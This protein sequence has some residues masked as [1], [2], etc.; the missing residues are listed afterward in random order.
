[1][2]AHVLIPASMTLKSRLRAKVCRQDAGDSM[3][4]QARRLLTVGAGAVAATFLLAS[5]PAQAADQTG[6]AAFVKAN[7]LAAMIQAPHGPSRLRPSAPA[8]GQRYRD[9]DVGREIM[10]DGYDWISGDGCI[11]TAYD[12]YYDPSHGSDANDGVTRSTPKAT[13]AATLALAKSLYPAGGFRIGV[14]CGVISREQLVTDTS[15]SPLTSAVRVGAFT[16]PN[17]P[18]AAQPLIDG[19]TPIVAA[20]W[21]AASGGGYQA[22]VTFSQ[23]VTS[24]ADGS[25]PNVY[26]NGRNLVQ[27]TSLANCQAT[28]GTYWYS[29]YVGSMTAATTVTLTINDFDSSNPATNGKLYEAAVNFSGIYTYAPG[30]LITNINSRRTRGYPGSMACYGRGTTWFNCTI[31]DGNKHAGFLPA[32]GKADSCRF[33]NGYNG[34]YPAVN[35]VGGGQPNHLVF[36]DSGANLPANTVTNCTFTGNSAITPDANVASP[37]ISG[38]ISHTANGTDLFGGYT[39]TGCTFRNLGAASDCALSPV[40]N[41]NGNLYIDCTVNDDGGGAGNVVTMNWSNNQHVIVNLGTGPN[42]IP[43]LAAGSTLNLSNC[44]ISS[45]TYEPNVNSFQANVTL[46]LSGLTVLVGNT[47]S[48]YPHG[49]LNCTNA[50]IKLNLTNSVLQMTYAYDSFLSLAA[51]TVYTGDRNSFVGFTGTAYQYGVQRAGGA[52]YAT[53]AAWQAA[54]GQDPNSGTTGSASAAAVYSLAA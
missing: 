45:G 24:T 53:L 46:N 11:W 49:V 8:I 9:T 15:A 44:L 37:G 35:G 32:G 5:V 18:S 39:Q 6:Q 47:S 3:G 50:G 40:Q 52:H 20:S 26:V 16:N 30:S 48:R 12:A 31:S 13:W 23:N 51:D 17:Y 28:Q 41:I 36:F 10:W 2:K 29:S 7:A 22:S 38:V 4:A 14:A 21:T 43:S 33:L 1:M 42:C 54:S 25:F 34:V 27:A 19:S